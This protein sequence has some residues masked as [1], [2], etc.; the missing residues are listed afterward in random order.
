MIR[1]VKWMVTYIVDR[2]CARSRA[3]TLFASSMPEA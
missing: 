3:D 1:S 2:C